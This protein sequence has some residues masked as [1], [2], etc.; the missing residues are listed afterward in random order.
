MFGRVK[1]WFGIEGTK[2]RLHVL[3][4]YPKDVKTINGEIELHSKRPEKVLAIQLKFIEVYTRGRAEEKRIDEF[5]LGT[6]E[7]K[8]PIEVSDGNSK[9]LFF[10][11]EFDPVES[12]MDKRAGKGSLLRGVVNI[13]KS[14]KGVQSDYRIE[15]EAIVEDNTWNPLAKTSILFD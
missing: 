13:M 3:P 15:A 11:L 4:S 9:T 1:K 7:Y 5:L 2:I 8:E 10:K 14:M 6:W 12:A